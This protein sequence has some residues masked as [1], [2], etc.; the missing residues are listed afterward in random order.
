MLMLLLNAEVY[1]PEP[2]GRRHLLVGAGK[3][4]WIGEQAPALDDS[5]AVEVRDLEGQ[6]VIPGI[7][8][9]HAHITGGG[10]E[11]GYASRI[12]PV[13]L[14][15]FTRAGVTTVVGL[16]GT[17]DVTRNTASLLAG[18][19]GLCEE[20][21]T[22]FCLTG[23]YHV[24]PVTLTGS[25]RGDIVHIDRVIGVGEIAISDHRSSQPTLD[26]LL[27][28]AGDAHVA[29]MMT[30]KAGIVHLH[31]GDG[32]RGLELV[33]RALD[34]S[35][36]PARVFNPTHVNRRRELFDEALAIAERGC[37]VDVTAYPVREGDKGWSAEQAIVRYLD[38]GLPA[39]RITVSSDGGGCL[40][41]FDADGTLLHMDVGSPGI[42]AD[43]LGKLLERGLALEKILPAFTGNPARLLRLRDKGTIDVGADAD[44]VVLG[45][46]A[47]VRHVMAGGRWHVLDGEVMIH[48]TIRATIQESNT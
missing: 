27:R 15:R 39:G 24:P 43:T 28:I 5:L 31:L 38:S 21:L 7:I 25:V 34:K 30:G 40:P 45:E 8:D 2:L 46:D 11:S 10:G 12:P 35:E 9:A 1:G 22:A 26:E 41:V 20:G 42:L 3:L 23:G 36:I 48:S 32:E 18:A 29:G 17:D 33:R 37:T 4:L 44:L 6:R 13:P 14:H 19:R 47:T 16:L